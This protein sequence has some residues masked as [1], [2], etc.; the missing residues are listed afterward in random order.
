[1]SF[2]GAQTD[3]FRWENGAV[4]TSDSAG[5]GGLKVDDDRRNGGNNAE[6]Q[7]ELG[8]DFNFDSEPSSPFQDAYSKDLYYG[9]GQAYI[10]VQL[11]LEFYRLFVDKILSI[12]KIGD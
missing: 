8:D 1:M 5:G 4:G 3:V 12:V 9:F 11:Q 7:G 10:Q 2:D 6:D